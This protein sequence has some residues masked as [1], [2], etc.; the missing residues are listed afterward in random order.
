M[1]GLCPNRQ[2]RVVHYHQ[3]IQPSAIHILGM[4]SH[5]AIDHLIGIEV[6]HQCIIFT[7]DMVRI[8]LGV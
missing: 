3:D 6:T 4:H 1:I 2:P 8:I 7:A 5:K